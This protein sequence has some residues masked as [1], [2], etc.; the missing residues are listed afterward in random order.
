MGSRS[1]EDRAL[2]TH[3]Q[4][5]GEPRSSHVRNPL[6]L[7]VAGPQSGASELA[8][9]LDGHQHIAVAP[10]MGW[11]TTMPD[12]REAVGPDG[13]IRPALLQR[14][15][16][17]RGDEPLSA[18]E[19]GATLTTSYA[20]FVSSMFDRH[21][22]GRGKPLAVADAVG[23]APDLLRLAALWPQ[24]RAIHLIRDGR[25]LAHAAIDPAWAARHM[26]A[27]GSWAGDPVAT[28]ALWW[29][30]HVRCAREAG[31]LLG[32]ERYREIRFEELARSPHAVCSALCAFL[33][34]PFDEAMVRVPRPDHH[35]DRSPPLSSADVARW[36]AVAGDLLDELGYARRA[37]RAAQTARAA[38]P[39][40][41]FDGRPL[42]AAAPRPPAGRTLWLTGLPSAGKSTV[43]RLVERQLRKR[44]RNVEVL[45]GDVVRRNLSQGLGFSKEDRDTN[46]RRIAY[47]ADLLSRNGVIVIVAA[48][49][50]YR[51][52][53][54]EARA[55]IGERFIEVHVHAPVSVCASRDVK[56]L[57]AK[58]RAG[59]IAHLTGVSDP[60]EPPTHPEVV[61]N[62]E[63]QTPESSAATL[64]HHLDP[65]TFP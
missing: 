61:L 63:H 25:E 5:T 64:L 6:A 46:I 17:P 45:D 37:P 27:L 47:V 19:L 52:V 42:P 29:E 49:S 53:R 15:V 34:V 50:P 11:L 57:Y 20:D 21:A 33:G 10:R 32:P 28:S 14:I 4:G 3:R 44:G 22:A 59:E 55:L 30:F 7:I 36:E 8:R 40:D 54:D 39:R 38:E 60:Y 65:R 51:A 48:I 58:A 56:G 26:P 41:G 2:A 16:D 13:M 43:A 31:I 62:T 9:L 18:D 24:T 35:V 23:M 1:V 12:D